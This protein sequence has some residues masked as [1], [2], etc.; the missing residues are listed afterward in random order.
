MN[1]QK[2]KM[3]PDGKVNIELVCLENSSIKKNVLSKRLKSR[4]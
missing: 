3:T 2:K 1:K 4:H